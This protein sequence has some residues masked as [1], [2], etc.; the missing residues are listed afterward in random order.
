MLHCRLL[1]TTAFAADAQQVW[2]ERVT[3]HQLRT[4]Q[5]LLPHA[6]ATMRMCVHQRGTSSCKTVEAY[7]NSCR[8]HEL[9]QQPE[10]PAA[11]QLLGCRHSTVHNACLSFSLLLHTQFHV[12]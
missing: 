2:A 4:E 8:S 3:E 5:Q 7:S 9:P 12:Q 11:A 1:A 6:A 10:M